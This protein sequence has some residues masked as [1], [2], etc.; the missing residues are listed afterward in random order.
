MNKKIICRE[1]KSQIVA[2]VTPIDGTNLLLNTNVFK[3]IVVTKKKK[4]LFS[5][6]LGLFIID[7][8]IIRSNTNI[9]LG[10]IP[11]IL[12]CSSTMVANGLKF[13][14]KRETRERKRIINA[15]QDQNVDHFLDAPV[16]TSY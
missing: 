4:K 16:H 5:F 10:A 1:T 12:K 11:K 15:R 8:R 3:K 6:S 7:R 9:F 14:S 13:E 2:K